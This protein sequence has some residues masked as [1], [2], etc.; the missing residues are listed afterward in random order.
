MT[1]LNFTNDSAIWTKVYEYVREKIFSGEISP[2]QRLVEAKVAKEIGTSRTP[3][4]EAFHNL[5][6]DGL[7][8]SIPRVGYRVKPISK[9]EVIQ[10]CKIREALEIIAAHWAMERSHSVLVG[11]L[12]KN[13]AD[14]EEKIRAGDIH[15]FADLD[16]QFHETIA[17]LSGS[18][19]IMEITQLMRRHMLRHRITSFYHTDIFLRAL[20]GHK[21]IYKA[22]E[23]LDS[24]EVER[25]IRYHLELSLRDILSV[26]PKETQEKENNIKA[27]S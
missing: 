2:G 14:S 27:H 18:N 1:G 17:R 24:D 21:L 12:S 13:I 20:D 25:A 23:R 11:E 10:I 26:A 22:M 7:I 19:H 6:K 8:E 9:E 16:A 5:Q 15:S 3:V 4:R